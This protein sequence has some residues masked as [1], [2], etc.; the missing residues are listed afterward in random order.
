M[1]KLLK[2]VRIYHLD[3]DLHFQSPPQTGPLPVSGNLK[4]KPMVWKPMKTWSRKNYLDSSRETRI[5]PPFQIFFFFAP[6]ARRSYGQRSRGG[7]WSAMG[8]RLHRTQSKRHLKAWSGFKA[9]PYMIKLLIITIRISSNLIV[10]VTAF[11][12][13]LLLCKGYNWTV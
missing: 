9:H 12:S 13:H 10:A 8:L 6:P 11:F 3:S 2:K 5:W 4:Y 1:E 7:G